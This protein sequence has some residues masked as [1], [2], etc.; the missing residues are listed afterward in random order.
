VATRE[1]EVLLV[2]A[3]ISGYTRFVATTRESLAHCQLVITELMRTVLK[4]LKLPIRVAKLEGDAV[5]FYLRKDGN[6][7]E[8]SRLAGSIRVRIDR[9]FAAF[10]RRIVELVESNICP[11]A[12]CQSITMLRLKMVVHSGR[13]LFFRLDRFQELSGMDVILVHRLLKNSVSGH[14]YVLLTEAARR[15]LFEP[16]VTALEQAEERYED[17]GA[18]RT[19]IY[20]PVVSAESHAGNPVTPFIRWKMHQLKEW[21]TRLMEWGLVR[22][23]TFHNLPSAVETSAYP[24]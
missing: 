2:I 17:V 20:R 1:Q 24:T 12:G 8:I 15:D 18:V 10:N 19:Y 6:E 13:A 7:R 4:E 11:C 21:T 5:F 14:E 22:M 3:D 23:P 9:M 16:D